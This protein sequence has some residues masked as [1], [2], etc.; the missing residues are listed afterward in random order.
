MS[1]VDGQTA[2]AADILA[3][4]AA[5]ITV[6]TTKSL[7]TVA[8]QRVLVFAKGDMYAGGGGGAGSATLKYNGV[9]KDIAEHNNISSS[10][11]TSFALMYTETPG[12]A[13]ADITVEG[14]GNASLRNVVICVLTMNNKS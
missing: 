8:G 6:A 5:S 14:G 4:V 13:T 12:A 9:Q 2:S 11:N 7:T 1:I 3:M 10:S